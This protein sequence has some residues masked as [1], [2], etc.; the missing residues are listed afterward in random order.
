MTT[1]LR[2][3]ALFAVLVTAAGCATITAEDLNAVRAIAQNAQSTADDAQSQAG[4][5]RQVASGAQ[6]TANQALSAANAA[7]ACC[8]ATNEKVDRMFEQSL[9]K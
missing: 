4:E 9:S 1:K 3:S 7:Q 2:L 5:A 6:S 8:D